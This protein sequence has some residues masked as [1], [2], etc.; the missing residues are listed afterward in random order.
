MMDSLGELAPHVASLLRQLR[1]SPTAQMRLIE[2]LRLAA[3]SAPGAEELAFYCARIL[4]LGRIE[5]EPAW[6]DHLLLCLE[7]LHPDRAHGK[8]F[9]GRKA[10]SVSP[11]TRGIE[12]ILKKAPDTPARDVWN[13]LQRR[14][15][16]GLTFHDGVWGEDRYITR[17]GHAR[18]NYRAFENAVSK[19]RGRLPKQ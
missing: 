4:E 2:R 19:A 8:R 15:P 7:R 1:G 14:P 6:R 16:K 9:K 11:L 18:T 13:A 10:G 12:R 17:E 5:D 3:A